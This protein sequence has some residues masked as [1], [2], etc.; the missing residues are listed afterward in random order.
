MTVTHPPQQEQQEEQHHSE[1]GFGIFGTIVLALWLRTG[2]ARTV[3]TITYAWRLTV[4][5]VVVNPFRVPVSTTVVSIVVP[6]EFAC[7]VKT[8]Q[9]QQQQ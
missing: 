9:Q 3:V 2:V 8:P 1:K 6:T 7:H 4:T 5:Y